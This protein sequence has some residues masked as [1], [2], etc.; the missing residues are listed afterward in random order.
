MLP[1]ERELWA[2]RESGLVK[3]ILRWLKKEGIFHYKIH[4]GQFQKVG[5]PDIVIHHKG[6][7]IYIEVKNKKGVVSKIQEKVMGELRAAGVYV[8]VA[9]NLYQAQDIVINAGVLKGENQ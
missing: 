7:T 5:L 4:G 8:G 3:Q 2:G 6:V 1:S 9:R